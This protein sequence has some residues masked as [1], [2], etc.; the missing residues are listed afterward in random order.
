MSSSTLRR[1]RYLRQDWCGKSR[2][3]NRFALLPVGP[4]SEQLF[5]CPVSPISKRTIPQKHLFCF[6]EDAKLQ[7]LNFTG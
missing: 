5:C 3:V 4:D 2:D 6:S 1:S 7:V